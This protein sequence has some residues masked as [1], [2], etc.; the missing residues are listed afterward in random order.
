M[1]LCQPVH[2]FEEVRRLCVLY[3]GRGRVNFV[4]ADF[5]EV[6]ASSLTA[7]QIDQYAANRVKQGHAPSSINRTTQLLGQ[8]YKL[9]IKNGHLNQMPPMRHLSEKGNERQGFF[10]EQEFRRVVERLP[11]D[12]QDFARFG[13]ATGMRRKEI[14]S[15]RWADVDGDVVKLLGVNAKNGR[16]RLIPLVGELS[17]IIKRR[18]AA[19]QVKVSDAVE[20]SPLIFDRNGAPIGEFKKSW[21]TACVAAGVGKFVCPKCEGEGSQRKCQSCK[22]VT[23]YRGRIFHDF[24][25]SAIRNM[26][27]A[28]VAPQIAKK[29]SGHVTDEVFERYSII[30]PNDV[31]EALAQTE[32]YRKTARE[33]VIA[34]EA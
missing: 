27:Q 25:R 30:V 20:I 7:E 16:A 24:R 4:K 12:L 13:F 17:E 1:A 3:L 23:T 8:S 21:A 5:G 15:L 26:V 10:S 34:M 19:R 9:A 18:K 2:A 6:R 29:V 31:R 33:K 22:T 28:G 11:E 14:K 32:Q